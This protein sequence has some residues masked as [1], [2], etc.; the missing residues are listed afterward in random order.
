M[1]LRTGSLPTVMTVLIMM[2]AAVIFLLDLAVPLGS[3]I[4]FLYI[5]P[6][7]LSLTL[8][9]QWHTF[10]TGLGCGALTLLGFWFS[11]PGEPL[12]QDLAFTNRALSLVGIWGLVLL[13]SSR[14]G[15]MQALRTTQEEL[16]DFLENAPVGIQLMDS[17]GRILRANPALLTKLGYSRPAF[18]GHRITEFCA[19]P[20]QGHRL[21]EMLERGEPVKNLEME[22]VHNDGTI[23]YLLVTANGHHKNGRLVHTR[24]FL[25]NVTQQKLAENALRESESRFRMLANSAPAMIW[26]C[27]AQGQCTYFNDQWCNFTGRGYEEHLGDGWQK[28]VHPKDR[29]R[30]L[31]AFHQALRARRPLSVEYRLHR[32]DGTYRWI[33]DDA[34]PR[35]DS[36]GTFLGF[37]GSCTDITDAKEAEQILRRSHETLEAL[38]RRRT[39]ELE[40]SNDDLRAAELTLRGLLDNLPIAVFTT[41]TRGRIE[42]FNKHAAALWGRHPTVDE[43]A[44][45]FFELHG[46]YHT[47]GSRMAFHETPMAQALRTNRPLYNQELVVERPDGS[48]RV[49]VVNVIPRQ[50][51]EARLVGAIHCLTDITERKWAEQEITAYSEALRTL[52]HRLSST[53]ETERRRLHGEL[54]DKVGQN[55]TAMGINLDILRARMPEDAP[56]DLLQR[57]NDARGMVEDTTGR[58]TDLMTELLPPMLEDLGLASALRSYVGQFTRRTGIAVTMR[59]RDPNPRLDPDIEIA[60]FRIFTEALNNMAKHAQAGHGWVELQVRP[61]KV[62]L[63][64]R[65]DGVG[66]DPDRSNDST[67]W[68]MMTMRE[69]ARSIGGEFRVMSHPGEGTSV[70]VETR[71]PS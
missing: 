6:V 35:T 9:S 46:M 48:R 3:G 10:L 71:R 41:D 70:I 7:F 22:F 55:L 37:I 54:H 36:D 40:L 38:V 62:R 17:Q 66:F 57:I 43:P 28:S 11:E 34:T 33:H 30:C 21:L 47:D 16:V 13:D 1:P 26:M 51:A 31:A 20:D 59:G 58:I 61:G 24:C 44:D 29:P 32:W 49:V 63:I 27:D 64:I 39:E 15:A 23:R 2:M 50:D 65:D 18:E 12:L 4:P 45:T 68:G 52:S 8:R 5:L 19:V 69:R 60:L 14:R 42:T 25:R 56:E 67:R 53:Q